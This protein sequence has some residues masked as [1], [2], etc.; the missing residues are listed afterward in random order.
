MENLRILLFFIFSA[1]TDC[2]Q[3]QAAFEEI[4][5]G[6]RFDSKY[7]AVT[8][9]NL[10]T[11]DTQCQA[12][13]ACPTNQSVYYDFVK[14]EMESNVCDKKQNITISNVT[15]I[16]QVRNT[17]NGNASSTISSETICSSLNYQNVIGNKI[18]LKSHFE[19]NQ[20]PSNQFKINLTCA[21]RINVN[22]LKVKDLPGLHHDDKTTKEPYGTCRMNR[23]SNDIIELESMHPY[24]N[25]SRCRAEMICPPGV[26]SFIHF[27]KYEMDSFHISRFDVKYYD[28]SNEEDIIAMD[29]SLE[30]VK[31]GQT[32]I[33]SKSRLLIVFRGVWNENSF[34]FKLRLT[35][36]GLNQRF[37]SINA[38]DTGFPLKPISTCHGACKVFRNYGLLKCMESG[39]TS[40]SQIMDNICNPC[41]EQGPGKPG[42]EFHR[43][44]C[45]LGCIDKLMSSPSASLFNKTLREIYSKKYYNNFNETNCFGMWSDKHKKTDFVTVFIK[46]TQGYTIP[47]L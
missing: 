45:Q 33:S 20:L 42:A 35:C 3:L 15:N 46:P 13:F 25:N 14:F 11:N 23:I 9:E 12:H 16:S 10:P 43:R 17:E 19:D 22:I 27:D 31:Q 40:S 21:D 6:C 7:G 30:P 34:G 47:V 5:F 44:Y 36:R 24:K 29:E 41:Q 26:A 8:Y 1:L 18:Y 4:G 32:F 39:R 37:N 28:G 2:N 38:V